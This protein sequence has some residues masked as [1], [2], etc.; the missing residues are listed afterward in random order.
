MRVHALEKSPVEKALLALCFGIVLAAIAAVPI[1]F[2]S[3]HIPT[4]SMAPAIPLDTYVVMRRTK[5]IGRGD[6]VVFRHSTAAMLKRCIAIG[7][8]TVEIR[9]KRVLLNGK[10]LREP[11]VQHDDPTVY[12]R[13]DLLPEP[14]RSRDQF[15]PHTVAPDHFFV[16]GDNRDKSS[17]SRYYGDIAHR[18]VLGRVVLAY[19]KRG[20]WR[21][22]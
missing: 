13:A 2:R 20:F 22:R 21:P 16:L 12:P 11:Y 3:Y 19:G 7:G 17:D 18:D 5:A 6:L 9:D 10:E 15:G 1:T 8:D 4:T 14:Y